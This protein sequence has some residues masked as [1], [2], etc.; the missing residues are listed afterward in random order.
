MKL[1]KNL[2]TALG[3]GLA[4]AGLSLENKVQGEVY[5]LRDG[6]KIAID[7]NRDRSVRENYKSSEPAFYVEGEEKINGLLVNASQKTAVF[8]SGNTIKNP[9]SAYIS[10]GDRKITLAAPHDQSVAITF[11]KGKVYR[12][13]LDTRYGDLTVEAKD[14]S[15]ITIKPQED[16]YVPIMDVTGNFRISSGDMVKIDC[17]NKVD[18]RASRAA[19]NFDITTPAFLLLHGDNGTLT[20]EDNIWFCDNYGR[21]FLTHVIIADEP[22]EKGIWNYYTKSEN[23][24]IENMYF[25]TRAFA[26]LK[27]K[28]SF[29][30]NTHLRTQFRLKNADYNTLRKYAR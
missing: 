29:W 19:I 7:P 5:E 21:F 10:L 28:N 15:C 12:N 11:P 8:L 16:D 27:D 2:A 4:S 18:I 25:A 14:Y 3:I 30:R 9:P 23:G 26:Q 6:T 1:I 20:N 13:G 24:N 17:K 22:K